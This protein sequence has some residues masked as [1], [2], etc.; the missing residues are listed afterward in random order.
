MTDSDLTNKI[1][2]KE[3]EEY[4]HEILIECEC[5]FNSGNAPWDANDLGHSLEILMSDVTRLLHRK[6]EK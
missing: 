6:K 4:F 3:Y 1:K 5:Y 2:L